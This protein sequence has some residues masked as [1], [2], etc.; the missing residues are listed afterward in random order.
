[1]TYESVVKKGLL[2]V[3]IPSKQGRMVDGMTTGWAPY[4]VVENVSKNVKTK[5]IAVYWI[6][7]ITRQCVGQIG[8][9]PV[10]FNP[11]KELERQSV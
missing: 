4:G 6:N 8:G 7:H 11:E 10:K 3:H 1:M 2:I 5:C 9:D